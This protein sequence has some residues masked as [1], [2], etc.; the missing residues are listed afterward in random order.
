MSGLSAS[1]EA[2]L[3]LGKKELDGMKEELGAV[4][5]RWAKKVMEQDMGK[6]S[7]D[8]PVS[9]ALPG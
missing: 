3:K 4:Y 8:E 6:V 7:L 9:C 2:S 5:D 1:L